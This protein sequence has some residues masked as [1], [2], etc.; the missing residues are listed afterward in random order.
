MSA[1]QFAD[2]LWILFNTFIHSLFAM[3]IPG[4]GSILGITLVC[5]F[6]TFIG[7]VLRTLV[8]AGIDEVSGEASRSAWDALHPRNR[9]GF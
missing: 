5:W 6:L 2:Q 1:G 4:F 7:W 8:G 9:I 3:Q